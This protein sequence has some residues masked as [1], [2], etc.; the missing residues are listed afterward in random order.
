ME[1]FEWRFE[2]PEV[3]N[4]DGDYLGFDVV[5]GNPPYGVIL[6][7]NE[8]QSLHYID[9]SGISQGFFDSYGLFIILSLRII[10]RVKGYL[11]FIV[12]N[13]WRLLESAESFRKQIIIQNYLYEVNQ[14]LDRVFPDAVVDCDIISIQKQL[15]STYDVLIN[16]F[17]NNSL[18]GTHINN[19]KYLLSRHSIN[20]FLKNSHYSLLNKLENRSEFV[21]N[22]FDIK[23]GIKP[24]EVGKGNPP[25]TKDILD[26]KPFTSNIMIS[27]DFKPLIGGSSFN[28]YSILWNNDFYIKY[29]EW[30]A[31]PRDPKIFE[32][33]EKII[34]RQTSDRL[35]CTIIGRDFII[36]NNTHV[37]LKKK[38]TDTSLKFLLAILNSKLLDFYY[39][40]MNPEKGEALAEVKAFH[41]ERLI[42]PKV[43]KATE[44]HFIEIVDKIVEIKKFNSSADTSS[45]ENEI[46]RMVYNL[47][48]MTEE[49]ISLVEKVSTNN[50][51]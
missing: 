43:D 18:I 41:I 19:T 29:G 4:D 3:L 49:E 8:F 32:A 37:I 31:A 12:P 25:Q 48:E 27:E 47:Y 2:F 1:P 14:F 11:A 17:K 7:K 39:W 46:D 16:L 9:G 50:L 22:D 26:L 5:I 33:E 15:I 6:S 21:S 23:N 42:Y 20:L 28:R 40:S 10:L 24:Y 45:F 35:I 34:I 44:N 51:Y 13:T 30:L 36:R 38:Y